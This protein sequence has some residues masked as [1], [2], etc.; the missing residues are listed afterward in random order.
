MNGM[1]ARKLNISLVQI[2]N[3]TKDHSHK[4]KNAAFYYRATACS[5]THVTRYCCHNSVCLSL[6]VGCMYCDETK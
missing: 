3:I 6:S 5:A 4:S 2:M 1:F